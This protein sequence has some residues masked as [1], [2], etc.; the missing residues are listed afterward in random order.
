MKK[1]DK[2]IWTDGELVPWKEANIH[3]MSHTLHYGLGIFEGIRAYSTKEGSAIFRLEDH[4]KRFY[5]SAHIM[6]IEIPYTQIE[7]CQAITDTVKA[8]NLTNGYI[9]PICYFGAE[10]LTLRSV[11]KPHLSIAAWDLGK[12]VGKDDT[13][14]GL[15]TKISTFTKHHVNSMMCKAKATGNYVNT[16]LALK[17][18]LKD[19]YDEAILLD[20]NGFVA[21]GSCENIFIIKDN[22]LITPPTTSALQGITRDCI[23]QLAKYKGYT[24]QEKY[25][26]RDFLYT[27]DEAFFTATAAEVTA[28]SEVDNRK[29]GTGHIG[30]ITKEL[31]T[32]Y[33]EIVYGRNLKF[34]HWL[35]LVDKINNIDEQ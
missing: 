21:E 33:Y 3:V 2:Y 34:K 22:Q 13:D 15:K 9:R 29:I 25:F 31:Q 26:T 14:I 4:I 10:G 5:E 12:Y 24:V 28:I 16:L 32:L 18:A 1:I 20:C 30:P 7:I 6:G 8:N 11:S 19:G 35:S 17:E 23:I 27:A